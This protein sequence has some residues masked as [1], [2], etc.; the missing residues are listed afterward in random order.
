MCLNIVCHNEHTYSTFTLKYYTILILLYHITAHSLSFLFIFTEVFF[1]SYLVAVCF[2]SLPIFLIQTFL[3]QFSTS[4][5]ISAFRVSPIF[6]GKQLH[7]FWLGLI[8]TISIRKIIGCIKL[9]FHFWNSF[10]MNIK[11]CSSGVGYSILV[12]N[13]G[14]LIYYSVNAAVPLIYAIYSLK[15]VMPWMSCDNSWNTQNCSTHESYNENV[16]TTWKSINN[17]H[18]KLFSY[19][20]NQSRSTLDRGI[21]SVSS[22][23]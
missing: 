15:T 21:L 5:A 22:V 11:L 12:L 14:T 16:S 4:G 7:I 2:Y 9:K 17:F 3:G 18:N 23:E 8:M 10:N 6:K 1:T 20:G 19:L 13:L